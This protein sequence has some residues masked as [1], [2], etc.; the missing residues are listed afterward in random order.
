MDNRKTNEPTPVAKIQT[1][2]LVT[3]VAMLIWLYLESENIKQQKPLRF[4]IRFVAP[5]GQK[6]LILP[7]GVPQAAAATTR[8]QVDITT[9]CAANQYAQLQRLQAQPL[10]LTVTE[11]ADHPN[12]I[13]DL[14]DMLL[15]GPV[16]DLGVTLDDIQPRRFQLRVERIEQITL[17]IH[18]VVAEGV[19]LATSPTL[20]P[21]E[22]TVSLPASIAQEPDDLK[23]E[24]RLEQDAAN[25]LDPNVP[26][27][28]AVAIKLAAADTLPNDLKSLLNLTPVQ[29]TPASTTVTVTIR[30]QT[31]NLT[32]TSLP[33]LLTAPWA[34]LNRFT[35][36]VEGGQRVLGNEVKISG[37]S[38]IIDRIEKGELKVWAD[39]RLTADDLESNINSK[40]LHINVPA[41]VQVESILPRLNFT[42]LPTATTPTVPAVAP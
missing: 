21:A 31:G 33:I 3:L 37:P 2:A 19:H 38:D 7:L 23:L 11:D 41:N 32:L 12:Q 9:S 13:V 39:L 24:A 40:Q 26:R 1:Y 42:I 6:L 28:L 35:V 20:T 8:S 22:A 18:V 10:E 4:A 25:R 17:P 30:K 36:E 16:G 34:E 5:P 14:R 29:I 15:E 27:E